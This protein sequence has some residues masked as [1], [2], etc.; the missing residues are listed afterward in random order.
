LRVLV[1]G[2]SD[3]RGEF[4]PGPTW[5]QIAQS[6][7]PSDEFVERGFSP[8][9][10]TAPAFVERLVQQHEPDLVVLPLGTFLFTVAFTWPRVRR[11]LGSR[12]ASRYRQAEEAF[13][14]KTRPVGEPP[15]RLNTFARRSARRL[16]GT[17]PIVRRHELEAAYERVLQ[18]LARHE[19]LDVLLVAY[20]PERSR[21]V[22][23]RRID[24]ERAAFLSH[25]GAFAAQRHF[26]LLDSEPLFAARSGD[27]QIM[28]ADGFHLE[29]QGHALL[30]AA[31]A[32]A[33]AES[34][35]VPG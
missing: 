22:K 31:V 26:R 35:L 21:L 16:L 4:A 12:L 9:G 11:L 17:R 28:T 3:T 29:R 19:D 27:P 24:E 7:L 13:D 5:T 1:L 23:V 20:P 25:V 6:R 34:A 18:V 30:G 8:I 33:I 32:A 10:E 14:A 15:G 2:N